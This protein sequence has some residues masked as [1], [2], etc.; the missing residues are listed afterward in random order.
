ML[1]SIEAEASGQPGALAASLSHEVP[2]ARPGSIFVG[3]GDSYAAASIA[4]RLHSSRY[5][6]FDPYELAAEPT[7]A[8]GRDVY[9]V[10]VSGMTASNVRAAEGARKMANHTYAVTANQRGTLAGSV[11]SVI[12]IGYRASPRTPGILSFSLSLL[13]LLRIMGEAVVGDLHAVHR[14]ASRNAGNVLLSQRGITYFLGNG[15]AFPVSQYAALKVNEIL[16]RPA[17]H[18][19][20]EEFSH[21]PLFSL[22]KADVVNAFGGYD[23]S[24]LGATLGGLLSQSGLNASYHPPPHSSPMRQAFYFIFLS[25]FAVIGRAN[26]LGLSRP[27][28]ADD[29]KRLEVS[30]S[31]IY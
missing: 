13:T 27:R 4:S 15:P 9:F 12:P 2:K 6:V 19:M 24:N 21:A 25:Q 23:P 1:S 29:L 28:F 5:M 31:M 8:R 14:Q 16:G 18:F 20:L 11:G 10:S 30:D 26:A 3:A 7:L 22:R 17:L